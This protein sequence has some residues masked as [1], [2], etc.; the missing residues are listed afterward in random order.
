MAFGHLNDDHHDD[1]SIEE[2]GYPSDQNQRGNPENPNDSSTWAN[3]HP[4]SAMW[5]DDHRESHGN[6]GN[7]GNHRATCRLMHCAMAMASPPAAVPNQRACPM[8]GVL[9]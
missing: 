4:K 2:F 1:P 6:H 3:V 5:C 9:K 7:H 8:R